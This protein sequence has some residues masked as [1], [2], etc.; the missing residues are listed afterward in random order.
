MYNFDVF[1]HTFYW[2]VYQLTSCKN[3]I[4]NIS[5]SYLNMFCFPLSLM[6]RQACKKEISYGSE[7]Q[8]NLNWF[9]WNS[10]LEAQMWRSFVMTIV[11]LE[12]FTNYI[13][14]NFPSLRWNVHLGFNFEEKLIKD[15][16]S[17]DDYFF[18]L[19]KIYR[20]SFLYYNL[21]GWKWISKI[22]K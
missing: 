20:F 13:Q 12:N 22:F 10:K 1:V 19:V 15:F 11:C 16:S 5:S 18:Y 8:T 4:S 9:M 14:K 17:N 7:K 6:K 3:H 2:N 21:I